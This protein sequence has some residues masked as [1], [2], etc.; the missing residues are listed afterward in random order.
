MARGP[1]RL[2]ELS[3]VLRF[4]HGLWGLLTGASFA[5]PLSSYL[6]DLVPIGRSGTTPYEL[7]SPELLTSLATVC[8]IFVLLFA[9]V[10]RRNLGA[11]RDADDF[12]MSAAPGA[13]VVGLLGLVVYLIAFGVLRVLGG[14]VYRSAP[15]ITTH[16]ALEIVALVSYLTFFAALTGAFVL[17]ALREY[18][19]GQEEYADAVI[20][21]TD[22]PEHG[23]RSGDLGTVVAVH[24]DGAL[25]VEFGLVGGIEPLRIELRRMDVRSVAET[26]RLC[27][28]PQKSAA[29]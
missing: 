7:L 21:A 3:D 13:L 26:D 4:L 5:F 14:D 9:L 1:G 8:C 11:E 17:L 24:D 25:K 20:L 22:I 29:E 23:L 18:M 12:I 2:K 19:S 15:L 28:R 27:V 6:F 10:Y 16:V